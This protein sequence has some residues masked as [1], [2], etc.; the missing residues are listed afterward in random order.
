MGVSLLTGIA[1]LHYG[2]LYI[3][4]NQRRVFVNGHVVEMTT[5]AFNILYYL[6]SHPDWT[7][8]REQLYQYAMPDDLTAGPESV[9]SRIYKIRKN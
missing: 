6:A 9:T 7:F 5:I 1:V 3:D 4:P 2:D 8:T